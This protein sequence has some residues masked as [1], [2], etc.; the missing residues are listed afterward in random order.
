MAMA[1]DQPFASCS[2]PR[3]RLTGLRSFEIE[4]V[5]ETLFDAS[6]SA[7]ASADGRTSGS[8][9]R[10]APRQRQRQQ[11]TVGGNWRLAGQL[12]V[13]VFARFVRKLPTSTVET[14]RGF[15]QSCGTFSRPSNLLRRRRSVGQLN[16]LGALKRRRKRFVVA[17]PTGTQ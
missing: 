9:R 17:E 15:G 16:G 10:V 4:T 6:A 13:G 2:A 7:S 1:A 14:G 5:L 3:S 8:G 12:T 11:V